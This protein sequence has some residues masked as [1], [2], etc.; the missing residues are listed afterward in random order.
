MVLNQKCYG[1]RHLWCKVNH[2]VVKEYE[3][4]MTRTLVVMACMVC[5]QK[6]FFMVLSKSCYCQII[7]IQF[8]NG[9]CDISG[10]I[11]EE[12]LGGA[13]SIVFPWKQIN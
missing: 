12:Q 3:C 8:D 9:T 11:T 5:I 10:I 13:K 4:N 2:D 1:H 7:R 6:N